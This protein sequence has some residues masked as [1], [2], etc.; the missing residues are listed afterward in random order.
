[1]QSLRCTR[2]ALHP[3]YQW[4][5][6]LRRARLSC[7]VGQESKLR[8][9]ERPIDFP[10]FGR[11][12]LPRQVGVPIFEDAEHGPW[13]IISIRHSCV[14]A[15][16]SHVCLVLGPSSKIASECLGY[17]LGIRLGLNYRPNRDSEGFLKIAKAFDP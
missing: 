3:I 1:M 8:F 2:H 16:T 15:N 4:F 11:G 17:H 9:R 6:K 13:D 12:R 7:R 14:R 10:G 5:S